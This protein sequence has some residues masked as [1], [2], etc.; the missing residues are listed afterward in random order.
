MNVD[1]DRL[2]T[3]AVDTVPS[4]V[5]SVYGGVYYAI[6]PPNCISGSEL[7]DN[8]IAKSLVLNHDRLIL[9]IH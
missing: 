6:L 9:F 4:A 7:T 5:L 3:L 8:C 2:F 1:Y